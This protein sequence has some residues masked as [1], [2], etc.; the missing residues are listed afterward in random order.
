MIMGAFEALRKYL[1][2]RQFMR[3]GRALYSAGAAL[4]RLRSEVCQ[5]L[6]DIMSAGTFKEERVITSKQANHIHVK[7]NSSSVLNFCANNYL[8]LSVR[9][10]VYGYS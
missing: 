7:G 9:S 1:A 4:T 8:G 5:Q 10:F 3:S 2:D 6:D